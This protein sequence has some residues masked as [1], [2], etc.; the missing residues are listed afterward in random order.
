MME[1]EGYEKEPLVSYIKGFMEGVSFPAKCT[2]E[3]IKQNAY[4]CRYDCDTMVNNVFAYGPNGKVF[5]GNQLSG[6][7]GGR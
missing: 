5:C 2:D 1:F 7:L 3:C 6:E 4:Y